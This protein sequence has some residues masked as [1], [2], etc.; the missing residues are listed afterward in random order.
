MTTSRLAGLPVSVLVLFL[1]AH[2]TNRLTAQ[3]F[4][5]GPQVV[6]GDYREASAN[7][8]FRGSGVGAAATLTWKKLAVDV[9]ASSVEYEPVDDGAATVSFKAKQVDVRVRYY[10]AGPVSAELGF[11]NRKTDPEFEAQS[12][13]AVRAGVRASYLLGPGV[14]MAV[15]GGMLFGPKFSG[16]GTSTPIG[17]LELGLALG[18]D[19]LRGRL[20]FTGDY[21]FQRIGRT[22]DD[23]SGEV[24]VPIEQALARV[25]IAVAF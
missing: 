10:I 2:P 20:R 3:H 16:G 18:V 4:V 22:T 13:G 9:A 17:A 6:F 5:V 1:T 11:V 21:E 14:R 7:L 23:G 19:A 8:H 24:D 12:V 25:G 15:R